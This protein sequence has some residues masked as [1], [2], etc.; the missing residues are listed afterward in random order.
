MIGVFLALAV[1]AAVVAV[2]SRRWQRRRAQ[3][4]RPG[5]TIHIPV[6]VDRFDEIDAAIMGQRCWCSGSFHLAGETS[7]AIGERRYR[8]VRLVCNECERDQLMYFD[9]TAVFH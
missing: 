7:R 9:V 1:I 4:K 5:A 2:G 8:V 3:L 6:V